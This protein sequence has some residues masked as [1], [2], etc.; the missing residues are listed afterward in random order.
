MNVY[1]YIY[2]HIHTYICISTEHNLS[3]IVVIVA[4]TKRKPPDLVNRQNQCQKRPNIQA[5]EVQ[6][7]GNTNWKPAFFL[8]S[9]R[10]P[11]HR[12][13]T[14]EVKGPVNTLS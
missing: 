1:I 8:F 12:R 14:V 2:I 7:T 4:N 9:Y 3:A 13:R 11:G 6:Y 10:G 5:K